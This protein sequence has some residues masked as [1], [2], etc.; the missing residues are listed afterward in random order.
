MAKQILHKDKAR[1]ALKR[2]IDK[3]ANAIKVTLGPKGR[4]VILD[5]GF[6]SPIITKDGV[7]VAKE[8]VLED[9][10]ENVAASL[11]KQA[12]EKT[13][14]VCGD[15]TTTAALLVQAIVNE[16]FSQIDSGANPVLLK[17][18]IDKALEKVLVMLSERSEQI[19]DKKK[20]EEVAAIAA[21]DSEIGKLIADIFDS[22]GKEGVVTVEESQ[23]LG[24]SR[25]TVEG[26]QFD[27]GY[28]SP[29]MIT[30][31]ERMEA[32]RFS[33]RSKDF[34]DSRFTAYFGENR[35]NR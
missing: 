15:G 19:T 1:E 13:N 28:I 9:K 8:I 12:S 16:G 24:L 18:G 30:N 2:G 3:M 7:T 6:G 17:T 4:N 20:I 5:R 22:I 11:V 31:T 23:T 25:E 29:Y 32:V 26:M 34:R 33:D 27:R 14:D 21:S 10:M 35:A